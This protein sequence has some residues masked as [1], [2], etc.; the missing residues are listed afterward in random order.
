MTDNALQLAKELIRRPSVTPDDAGCQ[1]LIADCLAA[2]GFARETLDCGDVVNSWLRRGAAPPL[3]AFAGHTDVVPPGD[4]A[5]WK[6]PPFAPTEER[7]LL[8]GRGSADMKGGLAAMV[9][10]CRRFVAEHPNH[11]GS[12]ALLLTSDEEGAGKDGTRHVIEALT[13][14]AEEIAWCVVGE[15]SSEE[16]VGDVIK[17]G[18][19]GSLSATLTVKGRQGHVAYP[20]L[21]RNPVHLAAPLLAKLCVRKWDD[22][23]DDFPPTGFQ[24][25]A[26]RAGTGADNV[27]P[28][29]LEVDFNFRF[30]P[31]TDAPEL[32]RRVAAMLEAE[33]LAEGVDYALAW[34]LSGQPFLTPVAPAQGGA[35][36]LLVAARAAVRE[37]TGREPRLSTAGGTSDARFIAPHGVQTI[38]LGVVN[39]S[40]HQT[41]EHVRIADLELLTEIYLRLIARLL[42][43]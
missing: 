29:A 34:R 32:R 43:H 33:G 16:R 40:I 12:L 2:S 24:I 10:A 27:I 8:Y 9:C 36:S 35:A 11:R 39:A 37:V 31:Q 26:V 38:E 7:G 22:G 1:R 17:H 15:P 13:R 19:R 6:H 14:R 18:R 41:D 3:L 20:Q 4:A 25:S 28:G 42:L 23:D 21:A 30:S 5:R